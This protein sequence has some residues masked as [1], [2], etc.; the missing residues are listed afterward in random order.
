M[1]A[2]RLTHVV[3]CRFPIYVLHSSK[4]AGRHTRYMTKEY[5]AMTIKFYWLWVYYFMKLGV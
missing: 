5:Q 2:P 1:A 3:K 4:A